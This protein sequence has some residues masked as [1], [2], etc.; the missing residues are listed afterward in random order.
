[1]RD[2]ENMFQ[3]SVRLIEQARPTNPL[4]VNAIVIAET[5]WV[6]ERRAKV[7]R[8]VARDTLYGFLET[9][10]ILVPDSNP[11]KAWQD[12]LVSGHRDY[13]DVV[14]AA[15]NSELGCDYT[16]TLDAGA[17]KAVPSMRLLP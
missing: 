13:S 5:L 6:L 8:R 4:V 17:A 15:I 7:E 14:I 3:R 11:L 12:T 1:M 10:Q 9:D 16:Y 2:D